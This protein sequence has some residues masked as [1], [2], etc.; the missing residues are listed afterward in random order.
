MSWSFV[1]SKTLNINYKFSTFINILTGLITQVFPEKVVK[2]EH[3]VPAVEWYTP[4]LKQLRKYL[5]FMYDMSNQVRNDEY[6]LNSYKN[7]KKFYAKEMNKVIT[8]SFTMGCQ[9]QLSTG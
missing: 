9:F 2:D 1:D 6:I 4:Y 8:R 5:S 3:K 7:I